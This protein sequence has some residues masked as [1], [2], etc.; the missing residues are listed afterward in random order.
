M[1]FEWDADKNN[2]NIRERGLDFNLVRKL[3][4][5]QALQVVD[6][7]SDYGEI[8]FR[9]MGRINRRL[10]V[11]VYTKREDRYRI[12]SLRKANKKEEKLYEKNQ[13]T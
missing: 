4:W 1:E 10:F 12:I 7:R 6:S 11:C 2:R 8:R 5:A 13:K 3:D 9:A